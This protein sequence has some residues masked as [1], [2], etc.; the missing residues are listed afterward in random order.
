MDTPVE[1]RILSWA[2]PYQIGS[3]KS[4]FLTATQFSHAPTADVFLSPMSSF[5]H[6]P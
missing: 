4:M 3:L 1:M 2:H 6:K 5:P